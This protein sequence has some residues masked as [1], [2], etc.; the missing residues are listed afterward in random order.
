MT[1][2]KHWAVIGTVILLLIGFGAA[3]W[4]LP[5]GELSYSERR[6]LAQL[7]EFSLEAVFD[8]EFSGEFEDYMLDQFPLRDAFRSFKSL[9]AFHILQRQ[10]NNGIYLWQ[11][12]VYKQEYPMNATQIDYGAKKLNEIYSRYLQGM[13]VHYA[14]IPDKNYYAAEAAGQ[15]HLDYAAL[16]AQ[17]RGGVTPEIGEIELFDTL[18]AESYYR[19][20]PHWRQE[21]LQ[22]VLDRLSETLGLELST[23][24]SYEQG[25]FE[26]FYGAYYGQ[27]AL[28]VSPDTLLYLENDITRAATVTTLDT[29]E[30]TGLYPLDA[31]DGMDAYDIYLG[32]AA[33]LQ[34]IENPNADT[35]REL[36]LFRDSFGSSLAPLLLEEYAKITLIDL[37]Y[38][39]SAAL[40]QFVQF[41]D[42]DVLFLYST[43]IWN[44]ASMLR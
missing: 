43:L 38:V 13:N 5:D 35:D 3:L 21:T 2:V 14:V 12:G 25:V 41:E 31:Y 6:K 28:A 9:T 33:A 17:L 30:T 40:G 27:S 11:D 7:P 22:P 34:V 1:K 36:I 19:T 26:N 23:V 15:L 29:G 32:G 16:K 18:T 42:Q 24:D 10:D 20:D 4:L 8:S 37:R 44:G 39:S